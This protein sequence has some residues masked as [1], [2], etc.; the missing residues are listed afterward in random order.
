NGT[1]FTGRGKIVI[2]NQKYARD[3]RPLDEACRCYT[4]RNF[5]RAYLRH[6]YER[7]EISSAV[8]NTIHNLHFYLDIFHE[9]RQS[10]AL[11]SY[12]ELKRRLI[13]QMKGN[14]L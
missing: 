3:Q 8:L 14:E 13:H 5:S 2:K 6:L 11:N 10:I 7:E 12:R 4:C 1:L 9:I